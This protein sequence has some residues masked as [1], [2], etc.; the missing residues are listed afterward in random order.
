M[1]RA[2]S[3]ITIKSF[4][5][6]T[7]EFS[8]IATTPTPDR[9]GD[10]VEPEG[11]LYKLPIPLL[12]QHQSDKPIGEVFFAKPTKTG[13]PIKGRV[14]KATQSR[15]LIER[16]DEAWESL[17][18][19][20]VRGLSIGFNPIEQ[21]QIKDTWSYRYM[22]WEWLEL[23][24]VTIP[25]NVEGTIHAIKSADRQLRAAPGQRSDVARLEE[26]HWRASRKP[27]V[28]YLGPENP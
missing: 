17:K 3:Q 21:A 14:F 4:D 10:I 16:L 6:E 27:G 18:I 5:E 8:G 26:R 20:L 25:A 12:W 22:K 28:V 11:A 7:R 15:T 23:S 19:G 13:I 9:M 2:Y 24:T 1:E